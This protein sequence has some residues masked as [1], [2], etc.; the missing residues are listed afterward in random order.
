[1]YTFFYYKIYFISKY[2]FSETFTTWSVALFDQ[3]AHQPNESTEAQNLI[4]RNKLLG[5][6]N[7]D[8]NVIN[9]PF[10]LSFTEKRL[11][12]EPRMYATPPLLPIMYI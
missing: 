2:L 8:F 11:K 10:R 7:F 5:F 3:L 1:M 12:F 6:Q 9:A 4:A